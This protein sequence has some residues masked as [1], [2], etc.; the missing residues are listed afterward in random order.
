MKQSA[1]IENLRVLV[2][3]DSTVVHKF[4]ASALGEIDEKLEL[5][6]VSDG[7]EAVK[8]LIARPFDIAFLDINMPT[9]SGIAVMGAIH[10]TG[11]K[12]FAVS[13]S[14]RLSGQS[15]KLLKNFGAYDFLIK[16]FTEDQVRGVVNTYRTIK[17]PRDVLIVDDSSTVRG[18]VRKVLDRSI[19]TFNIDEAEDGPA[20]LLRTQEKAFRIIFSDFNMPNMSGIELAA[21]LAKTARA[22]DVIM[23]SSEFTNAL[24]EAARQVG[25]RAFLRKP[26]YSEDVDSI[27]HH[28]FGLPHSYFS[29]QVRVFATT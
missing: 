14:N 24:D 20:A 4:I 6:A 17:K 5:I 7:P 27:L 16:P 9:L 18:I 28:I 19:F 12:T 1:N 23:M 21:V 11:G 13:M 3:D 22:S 26:F 10:E 25:A 8:A 2:A 15:E 29:K